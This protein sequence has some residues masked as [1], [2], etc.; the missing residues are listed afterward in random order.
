MAVLRQ[1]Y[2]LIRFLIAN[3]F[4]SAPTFPNYQLLT[5]IHRHTNTHT[6]TMQIIGAPIGSLWAPFTPAFFQGHKL[7]ILLDYILN[8]MLA[9]CYTFLGLCCPQM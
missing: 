9:F 5:Y 1:L 3:S 6:H 8:K 4:S 2:E 7:W